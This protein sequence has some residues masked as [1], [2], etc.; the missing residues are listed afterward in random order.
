MAS[1][2]PRLTFCGGVG[3]VTGANFLVESPRGEARLVDC[4]N[5]TSLRCG[6]VPEPRWCQIAYS[7]SISYVIRW[8]STVNECGDTA[9]ARIAL[10]S[11]CFGVTSGNII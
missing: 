4:G 5:A 6:F 8:L 3:D 7:E 1:A 10:I 9:A 2:N 11:G